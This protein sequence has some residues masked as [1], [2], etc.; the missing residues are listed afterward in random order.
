MVVHQLSEFFKHKKIKIKMV[1]IILLFIPL[2]MIY[3]TGNWRGLDPPKSGGNA[4]IK[5][6]PNT[7][8]HLKILCDSEK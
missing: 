5:S 7:Y 2:S 8:F 1:P 6:G 3:K 4:K